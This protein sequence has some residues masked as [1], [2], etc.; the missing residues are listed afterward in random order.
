MGTEET[1][2][3]SRNA[4]HTSQSKKLRLTGCYEN[5]DMSA[6]RKYRGIKEIEGATT[7]RTGSTLLCRP[8]VYFVELGGLAFGLDARDPLELEVGVGANTVDVGSAFVSERQ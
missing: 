4:E 2:P 3:K 8:L 6:N 1:D 7:T 5:Q